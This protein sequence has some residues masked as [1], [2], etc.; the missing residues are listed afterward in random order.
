ANATRTATSGQLTGSARDGGSERE[1]PDPL[2]ARP[3]TPGE[4]GPPP[5]ENSW[6]RL[7]VVED[8]SAVLSS[9]EAVACRPESQA[10]APRH[11]LAHRHDSGR[12]RAPRRCEPGE[13]IGGFVSV[14]GTIDDR[15]S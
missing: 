13:T 5:H 15:D 7:V 6:R 3:N 10:E 8:G 11:R 12:H 4:I 9:G 2:I 14:Q 1:D